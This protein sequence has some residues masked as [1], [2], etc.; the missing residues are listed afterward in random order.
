MNAK[1]SCKYYKVCGNGYS[2]KKCK[3]FIKKIK[4]DKWVRF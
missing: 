2:C 1:I 3:G 4:Q